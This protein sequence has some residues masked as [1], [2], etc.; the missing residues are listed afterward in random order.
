MAAP[1]AFLLGSLFVYSMLSDALSSSEPRGDSVISKLEH[2]MVE[3][4]ER[5]ASCGLGFQL[6]AA[7]NLKDSKLH[8]LS[9]LRHFLVEGAIGL[10]LVSFG[11][12]VYLHKKLRGTS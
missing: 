2:A 4:P 6:E 10:F 12:Q 1:L 8:L 7:K 11:W 3:S 9:A 5:A